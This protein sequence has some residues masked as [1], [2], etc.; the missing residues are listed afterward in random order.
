VNAQTTHTRRRVILKAS[1]S[2]VFKADIRELLCVE[3]WTWSQEIDLVKQ[4]VEGF[5]EKYRKYKMSNKLPVS[6]ARI[7]VS[8][9]FERSCED[10]ELVVSWN[11]K[12]KA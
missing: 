4:S 7:I 10:V 2:F 5:E 11:E 6:L 3:Y 8:H 9:V 1:G 12:E